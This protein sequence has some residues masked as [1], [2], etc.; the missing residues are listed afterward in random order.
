M[1]E[2]DFFLDDP[3]T[4]PSK[5]GKFV[6]SFGAW[7]LHIAK[8]AFLIYSGYHGIAASWNY[9]GNS[10]LERVAQTA[11]IVVLEVTLLSIYLAWHNQRITGTAQS[12]TAGATYAIGFILACLGIVADSQLHAAVEM[13]GWMVSYLKWGLPIA[14]AV[15]AIGSVLIHELD[16]T[17][18]RK[19]KGVAEIVKFSEEQ[20]KAKMAGQRAEQEAAK[21][22]LNMQLNAKMS[23]A[24]QV[25]QWYTSEQAQKAITSTAL[26]NAPALLRSIGVN[27]EEVPDANGNGRFDGADLASYLQDKP[28][29][30]QRVMDELN[31][32]RNGVNTPTI[33]AAAGQPAPAVRPLTPENE[34]QRNLPNGQSRR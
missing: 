22:I 5:E 18:L 7:G 19:R 16:P 32:Y 1:F 26:Q 27:V 23:A 6:G 15:M 11:G 3:D 2:K 14:P 30:A 33:V 25:E 13:S 31:R 10:D 24:R 9:A 12:I 21:L 34:P 28:E 29:M 8:V 20:F 4:E 17:Q